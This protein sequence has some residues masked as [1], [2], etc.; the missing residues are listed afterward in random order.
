MN[1]R[2]LL[3]AANI[4]RKSLAN[5][6]FPLDDG[7]ERPIMMV[8]LAEDCPAWLSEDISLAPSLSYSSS[9]FFF[10][11]AVYLGNL[12]RRDGISCLLVDYP[13]NS[14]TA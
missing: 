13:L 4:G 10:F 8:L 11:F 5:V 6:V 14:V 7:P 9:F 12:S 2:I 3:F 1:V